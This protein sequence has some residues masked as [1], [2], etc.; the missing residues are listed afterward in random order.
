[1]RLLLDTTFRVIDFL[2]THSPL[3]Q[4]SDHFNLILLSKKS[5]SYVIVLV[6]NVL[7]SLAYFSIQTLQAT[8][9]E[10]KSKLL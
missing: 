3:P 1:M 8:Y 4:D 10:P 6:R 9:L 2:S 5:D 7:D